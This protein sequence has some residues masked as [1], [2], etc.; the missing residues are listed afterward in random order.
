MVL[1]IPCA[2]RFMTLGKQIIRLLYPTLSVDSTDTAA[3]LLLYGGVSI[4]FYGFSSVLNGVLQG[5]GKVNFPVVSA[6]TALVFHIIL[7]YILLKYTNLGTL[8]FIAAT[9]LYVLIIV[10][11]NYWKIKHYLKYSVDW[12]N[13]IIMPLICAVVMGTA[14]FCLYHLLYIVLSG[15]LGDYICNAVSTLISILCAALVYCV[16]LLKF[17]GYTEEMLLAF[18]KGAVVARL[19]KKFHLIVYLRQ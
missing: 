2:V 18:P 6:L 12:K 9:L 15:V 16:S 19:A 13:V 5:V 10:G 17:G 4:I 14:A 8:S 11:M 7:L 1:T 3:A